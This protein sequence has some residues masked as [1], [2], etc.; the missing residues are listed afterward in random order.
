MIRVLLKILQS[1]FITF[2]IS[3]SVAYFVSIFNESLLLPTFLIVS[4]AQ[5][6]IF[7]F[8]TSNRQARQQQVYLDFLAEQ[9]EVFEAQ[10]AEV[11]CAAC[12]QPVFVPV[13]VNNP[14]NFNCPHCNNENAVYVSI[15]TAVTTTPV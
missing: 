3:G 13:Q 4:V 9:Q 8:Y 6:I 7:Y 14:E 5:F 15:E 12:K 1:L 2:G 10:G 11:Q